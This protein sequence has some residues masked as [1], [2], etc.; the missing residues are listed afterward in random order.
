MMHKSNSIGLIGSRGYLGSRIK[1]FLEKKKVKVDAIDLFNSEDLVR[2]INENLII[3]WAAGLSDHDLGKQKPILD[4]QRNC[5]DP[6]LAAQHL[7]SGHFL[8]HLSSTCVYGN[9]SGI[10]DENSPTLP[11]EPQAYSKVYA[12]QMLTH[13]SRQNDFKLINLRCSAIVGDKKPGEPLALIEKILLNSARGTVTDM[14]GGPDRPCIFTP[15]A[16]F[17]DV[18]YKLLFEN[19]DDIQTLNLA[20]NQLRFGTLSNDFLLNFVESI[21]RKSHSINSLHALNLTPEIC[22]YEN[23]YQYL[24]VLQNELTKRFPV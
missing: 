8:L 6:I 21:D 15:I 1:D 13:I 3:V 4:M 19:I 9:R 2:C 17:L 20:S 10:I 22:N 16:F 7:K 24:K 5:I 12:E 18:I 14:F 11:V 23:S